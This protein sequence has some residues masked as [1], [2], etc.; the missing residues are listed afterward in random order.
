MKLLSKRSREAFLVLVSLFMV[1]ACGIPTSAFQLGTLDVLV[2]DQAGT[3]VNGVR[4]ELL[5]SRGE[6][7]DV[8]VTPFPGASGP[9]E[10]R[11]IVE[12][13]QYQIR[14]TPPV[15]YTIPSNQANPVPTS[16]RRS[17]MTQIEFRL[18]AA[19]AAS[20]ISTQ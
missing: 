12:P 19:T 16:V 5:G 14:I 2:Q 9:G 15:G 6:P 7:R 13:A 10:A 3:G 1:P 8:Q 20:E 11:F 17:Q 18:Q 4:V